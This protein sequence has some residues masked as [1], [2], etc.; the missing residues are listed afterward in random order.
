MSI[1]RW[2]IKK[3]AAAS[4]IKRPLR[5]AVLGDSLSTQN[6]LLAPAWPTILE[7][8]LRTHLSVTTTD[9]VPVLALPE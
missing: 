5:I 3:V 2:I 1:T 7:G 6:Y 9:G 8:Y 4:F